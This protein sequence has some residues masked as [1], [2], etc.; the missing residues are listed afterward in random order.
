MDK[1]EKS[2][3]LKTLS[4]I[5]I[6]NLMESTGKVTVSNFYKV[7]RYKTN[8]QKEQFNFNIV[9]TKTEINKIICLQLHKIQ[10]TYGWCDKIHAR[11]TEIYKII[12]RNLKD[13][14]RWKDVP[15]YAYRSDC[16]FF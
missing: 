15:C 3:Y 9:A 7:A 11:D 16:K 4:Y 5:Y 1:R 12:E 8:I 10:N 13:L 2:F 14:D 6:E